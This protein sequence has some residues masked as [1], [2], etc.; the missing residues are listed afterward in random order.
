[1]VKGLSFILLFAA[2]SSCAVVSNQPRLT[3]AEVIHL[4]DVEAKRQGYN[5]KEY[6]APRA[7]FNYVIKDNTWVVFYDEKPVNG[8]VHIG[9]DF[10]VDIDDRTKKVWLLPGR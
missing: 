6:L 1:M 4:A 2:L 7:R 9:F 10:T 5:L 3:T 8:M